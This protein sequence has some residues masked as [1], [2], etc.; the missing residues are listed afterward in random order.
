MGNTNVNNDNM[1]SLPSPS[2]SPSFFP[3]MHLG[4]IIDV[5]K[6]I[7]NELIR[8]D[9][10]KNFLEYFF[11]E[12]KGDIVTL[13]NGNEQ[14]P[15]IELNELVLSMIKNL[16][17]EDKISSN[18][19]GIFDSISGRKKNVFENL[20]LLQ[21]FENL[22][23]N[24]DL[25]KI[26]DSKEVYQ[27][28]MKLK[29]ILSGSYNSFLPAFFENYN[30]SI[31]KPSSIIPSLKYIMKILS[32]NSQNNYIIIISDGVSK[33]D[34]GD[35]KDLLLQ[36]QKMNITIATLLLSKDKN[37]KN[38]FY[39]EFPNHL[40]PN[41]QGLFNI[42]S[43]VNYKN[44]F[45]RHYIK[46]DY[47]FP[48]NGEA[49]LLLETN[50]EELIGTNSLAN[51]INNINLEGIN[52]KIGDLNYDSFISFNFKF[53]A[54]NQFFGTCWA[55]SCAGAMSL[56]D[57][58]ILGKK[59]DS[60][61]T[62]RENIIRIASKKNKDSGSFENLKVKNFFES[63]RI[64]IN[65]V[66]EDE[67]KIALQKGRFILCSFYLIDKQWKNFYG[68]YHQNP[69]GVLSQ[70]IIDSGCEEA[71]ATRKEEEISDSG[72]AV[73]LIGANDNYLR[74]LNS[75]GNNWGEGGTFKIQNSDVLTS[76]YHRTRIE[77]Y[78]VVYYEEELT[79]EEKNYYYNNIDY[80]RELIS[81]FDNLSVQNIT[82]YINGLNENREIC[83]N[84]RREIQL[85]KFKV[86]I[87]NGLHNITCPYCNF[88]K[89]AD[90]RSK[91]WLILNDLMYDGNQ[92]FDINF[93]ESQYIKINRLELHKD[94]NKNIINESDCCSIGSENECEK[95]IDSH[96][97]HKVNSIIYL[98]EGK[99]MACDKHLIL[100]F[101]LIEIR[102]RNKIKREIETVAFKNILD[103][104]IKSLCDLKIG[105]SN[106][107]ASGGEELKIFEINYNTKDLILKFKFNNN[108]K[109]N[110]I[111]SIDVNRQNIIKRI[112]VCDKEGFI[113]IY[114]IE[115]VNSQ[116]KFSFSFKKRCHMHEIDCILYIPEEQIL[117]SG[118]GADR[119]IKFWEIQNNNL[120][121]K[122][123]LRNIPS[124]AYHNSLLNINGNLLIGEEN[125]IRVVRHQ[126]KRIISSYFF[127][128]EDF[129]GVF[130]MK[131][132][133]NNYFICGRSF[134][135]CS[136]FL[137][138]E[139]SIRK[140][141]I[142]RNNNLSVYQDANS[143]RNDEYSITDICIRKKSETK[144]NILI[145][146]VDK[147]LKVYNYEYHNISTG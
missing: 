24:K 37:I 131:H 125:G 71:I 95:K 99:L 145:S 82:N 51:N 98:G 4:M 55:N 105:N 3:P 10:E 100:V 22:I 68:Y 69:S 78:D 114:N 7:Q 18:N 147:T 93:Q 91:E 101:K 60:F 23:K 110:K 115:N 97:I 102:T 12:Y 36:A 117:V 42:S 142:F 80:I 72:H 123:C 128:D 56:T 116:L 64:H 34:F 33:Q 124:T 134:G 45:A 94:F 31:S 59:F 127:K 88:R 119:N 108:K 83:E 28:I 6:E 136:L 130:A 107:I 20:T 2:H 53:M 5:S 54:K 30:N 39:N 137:L 133:G 44:P 74:F 63:K 1:P 113:G 96:F 146:S 129:G 13:I 144:G 139:N 27:N 19:L 77:F 143:T 70:N 41:I 111:F 103:E 9:K 89:L 35:V 87:E 11:S 126:H 43:K 47:D 14:I 16:K 112:I 15:Y 17:D 40:N 90:G 104:N 122:D 109:I 135:Y 25:H 76:Y 50:F 62:N 132:L 140:I 79:K 52:I 73:L 67:A 84:C 120:I 118:S 48:K 75:W 49:R 21:I 32:K 66:N 26:A 81:R 121:L 86:N 141:N 46:K 38:K 65:N 106:L 8:L 138:R 29:K 58:R 92:D 57:K 85:N 61:Q